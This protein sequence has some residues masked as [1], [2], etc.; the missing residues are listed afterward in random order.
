MWTRHEEDPGQRNG[1]V[2]VARR[3]M[4][5]LPGQVQHPLCGRYLTLAPASQGREPVEESENR[6]ETARMTNSFNGSAP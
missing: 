1:Q 4:L 2:G 6:P 5:L 3:P